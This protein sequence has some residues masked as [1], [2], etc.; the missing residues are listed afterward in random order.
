MF[1][2]IDPRYYIILAPA[3]LLGM[4]AQW[5]VRSSFQDG[6]NRPARLSGAAAARLILDQGGLY[7]VPIE[8]TPGELSD[9]FDP[10]TNTVRLSSAVYHTRSLSAVGIAAHEVGHALQHAQHYAPLVIRN[11]A[12]PAAAVGPNLAMILIIVGAMLRFPPM[13][14]IGL[15]VF[16]GVVAFQLINLPVEFDASARAKRLLAELNVVDDDGVVVVRNV[17]SA[18]A[19]TYVAATLQ[20]IL[21]LVYLVLRFA[22]DSG[23][24]RNN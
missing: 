18:A 12:V 13:V 9:H 6:M 5:R 2:Y 14:S 16:S 7:D 24:S 20:T 22:G 23:R 21:T 3:L 8:E 4:W 10:T 15:V 11:F 17:L 1:S 19:W